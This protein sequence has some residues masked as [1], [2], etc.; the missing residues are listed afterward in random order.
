MDKNG[1]NIHQVCFE[2]DH[3]YCPVVLNNGRVLYLRW[4]YT[5]T[6]HVWNRILMSMN[7]DGTGQ[8]EY[9]GSGSYWPNA[10]FYARPIPIILRKSPG[11]SQVTMKA[12]WRIGHIRSGQGK[13]RSTGRGPAY[14]RAWQKSEAANRGQ[15]HRT[16]LAQISSSMASQ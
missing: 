4:D 1:R 16:Q 5:D 6:P 11:L 3:D 13:H 14:S 8:M 2:Q 10:V 12:G 9:Y 15:T 7:P